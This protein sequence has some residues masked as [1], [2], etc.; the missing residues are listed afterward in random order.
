MSWIIIGTI[1]FVVAF[2]F[3][4]IVGFIFICRPVQAYY[5]QYNRAW[6]EANRFKCAYST[7]LTETGTSLNSITDFWITLLPLLFIRKLH[8]HRKQKWA[9]AILFSCG[10]L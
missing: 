3:S 4:F 8:M 10:F 7:G 9:L 6:K 2:T 5:M 1:I